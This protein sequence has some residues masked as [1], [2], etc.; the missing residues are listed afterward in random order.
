MAIVSKKGKKLT[1]NHK[2]AIGLA[3]KGKHR[4]KKDC[5]AHSKKI[6]NL[7]N[8]G[9]YKNRNMS[10][11]TKK[12]RKKVSNTLKRAWK[13]GKFS[14]ERN[15]KISRTH[16]KNHKLIKRIKKECLTCHKLFEI[17]PSLRKQ[18]K[19]CSVKCFFNNPKV[20]KNMSIRMKN[21]K[22]SKKR[23]MKISKAMKGR[24]P[25]NWKN[26]MRSVNKYW[27]RKMYKIIK[28]YYKNVKY[29]YRV[30]INKY[31]RRFLDVAII[32]KKIDFEYDGMIHLSK[33]V[34]HNDKIRDNQLRKL[35]WK[36]IRINKNNY[37]NLNNILN[38]LL[39]KDIF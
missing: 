17:V 34:K 13:L 18:R 1:K 25:K 5:I 21:Y 29:E 20:R 36:I 31:K 15:K 16:Q 19:Y 8:R 38:R 6:K 28:K 23:N 12:F 35:G 30:D 26:I 32:D 10:Y 4:S 33:Y 39:K 9:R 24:L 11:V 22:Y 14:K 3:N 37:K 2:L 27:Q 7:W